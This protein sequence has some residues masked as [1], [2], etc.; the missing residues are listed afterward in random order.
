MKPE[1]GPTSEFYYELDFVA[2]PDE[3]A[4]P[5][6]NPARL[7]LTKEQYEASE[8]TNRAFVIYTER[9]GVVKLYQ[10]LRSVF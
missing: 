5:G 1:A 7:T 6:N 10:P 8:W 9:L 2:D 3:T 4:S